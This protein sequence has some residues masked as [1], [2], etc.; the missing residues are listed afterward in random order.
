M[1][2]IRRRQSWWPHVSKFFNPNIGADAD[3]FE[4]VWPA[5]LKIRTKA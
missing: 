4:R 5:T 3:V 1:Q 2:A